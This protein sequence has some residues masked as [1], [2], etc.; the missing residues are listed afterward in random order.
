MSTDELALYRTHALPAASQIREEQRHEL[1]W[2]V[3]ADAADALWAI[4]AGS[5]LLFTEGDD[6]AYR[7]SPRNLA[8]T[9]AAAFIGSHLGQR[10]PP[11]WDD[12]A[13]MTAHLEEILRERKAGKK[14]AI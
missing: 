6:T 3:Y 1:G 5:E 4:P 11:M 8:W 12:L 13:E 9:D 7:V 10:L 14:S 2:T